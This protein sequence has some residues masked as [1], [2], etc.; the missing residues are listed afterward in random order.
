MCKNHKHDA[1]NK[2]EIISVDCFV[3]GE[4]LSRRVKLYFSM[5]WE[6]IELSK[7]LYGSLDLNSHGGVLFNPWWPVAVNLA[8]RQF[9][10]KVGNVYET[11]AVHLKL[12][13]HCLTGE[14]MGTG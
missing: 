13:H 10:Y 9:L 14:W 11:K 5:I 2:Q 12:L 6:L 7:T 4:S 3:F 1:K 8:F